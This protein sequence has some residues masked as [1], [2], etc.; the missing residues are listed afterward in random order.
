VTG[1]Q[2][3]IVGVTSAVAPLWAGIQ[4]GLNTRRSKPL[5]QI[6]AVL[7]GDPSALRDIVSGDNTS[8][9]IGFSA[10]TGWDACTGLGSPVGKKLV[11]TLGT[12]NAG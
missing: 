7:Y 3:G 4:A 11:K 12:A 1:G 9:S 6:H 8:G 5:G 2:T 10:A